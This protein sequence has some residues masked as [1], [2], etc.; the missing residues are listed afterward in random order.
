MI[1]HRI[2]Y[3]IRVALQGVVRRGPS[4]MLYY[5]YSAACFTLLVL[6]HAHTA[7]HLGQVMD[8]DCRFPVYDLDVS[9]QN[10]PDLYYVAHVAA[11]E[12]Y[13]LHGLLLGQV[14]WVGS[15]LCRSCTT[16]Q[17]DRRGSR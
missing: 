10:I 5:S 2:R 7:P 8:L 16:P 15:V 6:L 3:D 17:N 14:S 11:C 13:N 12:P 4:V 1:I 9:G